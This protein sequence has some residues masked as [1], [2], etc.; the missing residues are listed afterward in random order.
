MTPPN[1]THTRTP[2]LFIPL[3][4]LPD[5]FFHKIHQPVENAS[6]LQQTI[7]FIPFY[8]RWGLRVIVKSSVGIILY[9]PYIQTDKMVEFISVCPYSTRH[10]MLTQPCYTPVYIP[11]FAVLR[12]RQGLWISRGRPIG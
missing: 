1:P 3:Q 8:S 9:Y 11:V 2:P 5:T 10:I 6:F 12:A 4:Q 7:L